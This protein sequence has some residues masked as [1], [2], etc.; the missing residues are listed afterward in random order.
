MGAGEMAQH[1]N[2]DLSYGGPGFNSQYPYGGSQPFLT[3]VPGD[4]TPSSDLHRQ[5]TL[6]IPIYRHTDT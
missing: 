4:S 6:H 5:Y 3:L 1:L 2:T